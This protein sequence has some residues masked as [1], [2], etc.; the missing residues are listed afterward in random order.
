M[1]V[2]CTHPAERV[3]PAG[4]VGLLPPIDECTHTE[5]VAAYEGVDM[6]ELDVL[7]VGGS[8]SG[9]RGS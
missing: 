3:V 6:V 8:D 9:N 7:D 2:S 1:T 5:C 4:Y